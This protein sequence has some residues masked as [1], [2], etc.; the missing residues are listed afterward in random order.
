MSAHNLGSQLEET[1]VVTSGTSGKAFVWESSAPAGGESGFAKGAI[2]I[3]TAGS[4]TTTRIY[5]NSGSNTSA[6][7]TS[8]LCSA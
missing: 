7:W 8:I 4:S 6:T 5:I 1:S 3:N 2:W